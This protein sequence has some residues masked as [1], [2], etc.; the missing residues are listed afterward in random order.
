MSRLWKEAS[1]WDPGHVGP[2]RPQTADKGELWTERL[3]VTHRSLG[4]P[5]EGPF[6][7]LKL[8]TCL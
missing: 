6:G 3:T 8:E 1:S 7:S 4:E 5:E 2:I